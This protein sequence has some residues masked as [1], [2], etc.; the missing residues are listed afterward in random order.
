M[1]EIDVLSYFEYEFY[2]ILAKGLLKE[3]EHI[4]TKQGKGKVISVNVL[5]RITTVELED[6]THIEVDFN[7]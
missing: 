5:K 2:K 4:N 6:G 7:A 3:G 1:R